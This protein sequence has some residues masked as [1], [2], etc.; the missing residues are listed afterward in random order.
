MTLRNLMCVL[1]VYAVSAWAPTAVI[2]A[3]AQTV[4]GMNQTEM[5]IADLPRCNAVPLH[6]DRLFADAA[7][8][9]LSERK[10]NNG[11]AEVRYP[12]WT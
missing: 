7:L 4:E 6:R 3:E 2:A 11:K 12:C 9:H 8:H 10:T 1:A 5:N